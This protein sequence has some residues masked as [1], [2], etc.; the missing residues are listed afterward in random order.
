MRSVILNT[1]TALDNEIN[2]LEPCYTYMLR[3][4]Q[5]RAAKLALNVLLRYY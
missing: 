4:Q 1:M 2:R 3:V 5:L